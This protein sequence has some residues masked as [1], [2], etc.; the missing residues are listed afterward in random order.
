MPTFRGFDFLIE[1]PDGF[2]D[3]STYAFTIPTRAR[4]QPSIVVK[5]ERLAAAQALPSYVS[6]QLD[7][8][9]KVLNEFSLMSSQ[10]SRH[11][12]HLT[13][14]VSY[15]W[16]PPTQRVRQKQLYILL[17]APLRVTCLTAT[18]LSDLFAET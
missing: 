4:F 2:Q 11:G 14:V 7:K 15:E 3:E 1:L 8:I 5:T 6:T 13:H 12:E 17:P 18:N 9:S 10:P 16:G